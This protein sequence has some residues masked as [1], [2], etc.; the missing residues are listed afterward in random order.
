MMAILFRDTLK[1]A[2][3]AWKHTI[4]NDGGRCPCCGKWG[5]IYA[6]G[7]SKVNA[8][9]LLWLCLK[10]KETTDY[11]DVRN[12][13]PDYVLRSTLATLFWWKLIEQPTQ[14]F[15]TSDLD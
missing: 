3:V 5:K 12:N 14:D 6:Y 15:E 1:D 13:V 9:A 11:I 7:I 2:Q 10:Q 8:K 4:E